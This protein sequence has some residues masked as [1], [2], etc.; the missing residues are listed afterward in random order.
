M[1]YEKAFAI[2]DLHFRK[3]K[4]L[5]SEKNSEFELNN[6]D[7]YK[8]KLI[9]DFYLFLFI[10][11]LLLEIDTLDVK[12]FLD[13][14]YDY[15]D[16]PDLLF[17]LLDLKVIPKIQDLIEDAEVNLHNGGYYNEIKLDDGFIESQG[18]IFNY[19]YD[20]SMMKHQ[21]SWSKLQNDCKK[22]IEIIR[23]F[24]IEH[25]DKEE[26]QPLKWIAGPS[27]LGIIIRELIEKGYMEA[28]QSRGEINTAALSKELMKAFSIK[29]CE[30]SK[31][32][33]IYLSPGNPRYRKA[34][35]TF[36]DLGFC[37]PIRKFT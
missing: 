24:L 32:I 23:N 30:S 12:R 18:V 13:Y 34:K 14:H 33:Q 28:D 5:I 27:Q 6:F 29:N 36:D 4:D 8:P 20:Y 1:N 17:E 19:N 9:K 31:S 22:R 21:I 3:R 10:K 15:C 7:Y 11:K 16:D 35:A 37:I 25:L 26:I 2:D